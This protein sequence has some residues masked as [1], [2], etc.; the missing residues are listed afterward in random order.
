VSCA[1]SFML[2]TMSP[3]I[4][5]RSTFCQKSSRRVRTSEE[6]SAGGRGERGLCFTRAPFLRDALGF[7]R[8]RRLGKADRAGG[9]CALVACGSCREVGLRCLGGMAY[10]RLRDVRRL[11]VLR[12][13][14]LRGL[15]FTGLLFRVALFSVASRI[16]LVTALVI[17]VTS[18]NA[19]SMR[20]DRASW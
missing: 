5:S 8:S 9:D 16:A 18:R 12:A 7:A 1:C 20:A 4:I 6:F 13:A 14:L 11:A 2:A 15:F 3:L 17:G 10:D 19:Q